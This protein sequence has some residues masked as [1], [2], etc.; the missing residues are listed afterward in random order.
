VGLLDLQVKKGFFVRFSVRALVLTVGERASAFVHL[1]LSCWEFAHGRCVGKLSSTPLS[2]SV[3][4]ARCMLCVYSS[5][6]G[7][8][9]RLS[10]MQRW[11]KRRPGRQHRM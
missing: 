11:R 7:K 1:N 6:P 3:L 4:T 2:L 5:A 9:R 10:G 8:L